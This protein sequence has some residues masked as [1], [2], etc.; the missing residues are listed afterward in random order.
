M[1]RSDWKQKVGRQSESCQ[2]RPVSETNPVPQSCHS[3]VTEAGIL[4]SAL[5]KTSLNIVIWREFTDIQK[6]EKERKRQINVQ[7]IYMKKQ[8]SSSESCERIKQSDWCCWFSGFRFSGAVFRGVLAWEVRNPALLQSRGKSAMTSLVT[9]P[10]KGH[11][12]P[13]EWHWRGSLSA[14]IQCRLGTIKRNT[15]THFKL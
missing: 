1:F 9:L 8:S 14:G 13:F 4:A 3:K 15:A 6:K 11:K 7:T 10:A 2:S 5:T 12:W